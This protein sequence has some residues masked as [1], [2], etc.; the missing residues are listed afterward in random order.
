MAL[1]FKEQ[2]VARHAKF[3]IK[4]KMFRGWVSIYRRIEH[5]RELEAYE[6]E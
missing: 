3:V 1:K 5:Q 2:K 4:S 6:R